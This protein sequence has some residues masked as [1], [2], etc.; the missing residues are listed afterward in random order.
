MLETSINKDQLVISKDYSLNDLLIPGKL[1]NFL[2]NPDIEIKKI[3]SKTNQKPNKNT[4]K[5]RL[6]IKPLEIISTPNPS[7]LRPP[8]RI[9]SQ[10]W[11][12]GRRDVKQ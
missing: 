7:R 6:N 5:E 11:P 2:I 1:T 8:P 3:Q 10:P 4:N 12:D 9:I